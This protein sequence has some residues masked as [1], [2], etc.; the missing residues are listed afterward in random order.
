MG[1]GILMRSTVALCAICAHNVW[2][3]SADVSSERNLSLFR[4]G[5]GYARYYDPDGVFTSNLARRV[6]LA[7]A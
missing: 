2:E 4:G 3:G 6:G 7:D 1:I 5:L